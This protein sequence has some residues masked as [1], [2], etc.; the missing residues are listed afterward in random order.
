MPLLRSRR[1]HLFVGA[2][3]A[4]GLCLVAR[5]LLAGRQPPREEPPQVPRAA[6]AAAAAAAPD[7]VRRPEAPVPA[8]RPPSS[9][10]PGS[11]PPAVAAT[12]R[13]PST[14]GR[15]PR[16]AAPRVTE[17]PPVTPPEACLVEAV[18]PRQTIP[19]RT[20]NRLFGIE[21]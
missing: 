2:T 6:L 13:P 10:E 14:R 5:L 3:L 9:N 11:D 18:A 4:V 21:D 1:V 17:E 19:K 15:E 8:L 16:K 12:P 7:P 20:S